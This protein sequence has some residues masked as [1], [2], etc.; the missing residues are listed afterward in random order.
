[1]YS[2]AESAGIA[3]DEKGWCS[4]SCCWVVGTVFAVVVAVVVAEVAAVTVEGAEC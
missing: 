3:T 1:M 2:T 4:S